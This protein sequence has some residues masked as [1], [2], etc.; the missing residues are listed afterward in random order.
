MKVSP[1][2]EFLRSELS[3]SQRLQKLRA[4]RGTPATE[5]SQ[6]QDGYPA[7]VTSQCVLFMAM[8]A[9]HR[10]PRVWSTSPWSVHGVR[11]RDPPPLSLTPGPLL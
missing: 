2:S 5:V 8:S 10:D 9:S 6:R 7:R 3:L 4:E 1:R 11:G